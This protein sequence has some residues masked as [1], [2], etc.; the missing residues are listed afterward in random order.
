MLC[1]GMKDR[2]VKMLLESTAATDPSEPTFYEYNLRAC[3][4][5]TCRTP[6]RQFSGTL[7]WSYIK[8][9]IEI[10][11]NLRQLSFRTYKGMIIFHRRRIGRKQQHNQTSC[12]KSNIRR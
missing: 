10:M 7:L 11:Y 6:N 12:Y 3:L 4:V 8:L 9:K 1:I 2:A 5:A